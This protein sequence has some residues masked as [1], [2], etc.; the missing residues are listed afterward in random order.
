MAAQRIL[1]AKKRRPELHAKMAASPNEAAVNRLRQKIWQFGEEVR[2][3]TNA[4]A[5]KGFE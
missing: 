5:A 4:K 3:A 2:L 1:A